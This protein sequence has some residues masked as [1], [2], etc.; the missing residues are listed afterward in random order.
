M[1]ES[2][3][4]LIA[5]AHPAELAGLRSLLGPALAGVVRGLHVATCEVGVGLPAASA[6]SVCRLRDRR[7][8]ALILL[9]SCGAYPATAGTALAEDIAPQADPASLPWPLLQ[10]AIPDRVLL[11]D[12]GVA[13]GQAAFP[14]PMPRT[15][16]IDRALADGLAA[17]AR[18]PLRG[19]LATTLGITTSNELAIRLERS[20]GCAFENLEALGVAL[21]C[22]AERVPFA[23]LLAITNHVG[24]RGRS[25][26]LAHYAR[27][28]ERGAEVLAKWLEQAGPGLPA[29]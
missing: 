1:S 15:A 7:P 18:S 13:S 12:P 22:A 23:A 14:E 9:G 25:Q 5:A 2:L 21:A 17:C 27:A 11:A 29:T 20:S 16:P 19:A 6:A 3:D 26:W 28:A 8:R 4:V 10:I 24:E